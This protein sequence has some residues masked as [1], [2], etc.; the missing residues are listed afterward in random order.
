MIVYR[1][2][3]SGSRFRSYGAVLGVGLQRRERAPAI[4]ALVPPP[5]VM[6]MMP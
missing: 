2:L 1:R 4:P 6:T 5:M 3:P